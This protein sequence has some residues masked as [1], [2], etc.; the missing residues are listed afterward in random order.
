[1]MKNTVRSHA[2]RRGIPLLA[3]SL[4][5]A[6]CGSPEAQ[7]EPAAG[8]VGVAAESAP[9]TDPSVPAETASPAQDTID[10]RRLGYDRGSA[11]APV[12]VMEFAD[13]GCPFCATFALQTYPELHREFVAT[14]KVRWKYVPFVMGMFPNGA[15]A[16]RAAE[17]AAEQ[18]KFWPMHD[19][20][21]ER[22]REWRGGGSPAGRMHGY[23]AS[24]G[25]DA[26]RFAACYREDRGG[27]RTR[28]NNHVSEQL[29]IRAT[30]TFI[31]NGRMVEGAL[32]LEQFRQLLRQAGAR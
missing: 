25:A 24:V 20:L 9:V 18:G 23:A 14:G 8:S 28:L 10:L 6:A 7:A 21:Y 17:C 30:P 26:G 27:G 4:L 2:F 22:Q 29:G 16:A 19:R 1:M 15:E 3:A 13:F 32:P 5:L 31:V 11:D 12:V